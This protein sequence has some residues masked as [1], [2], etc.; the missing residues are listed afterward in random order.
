MKKRNLILAFLTL[1]LTFNVLSK[2]MDSKKIN[3]VTS[4]KYLKDLIRNVTCGDESLKIDVLIP[5]G[6]NP[7]TFH[8]D[9]KNKLRILNAKLLLLI[10][11]DLEGWSLKLNKTSKFYL[12]KHLPLTEMS[13]PH[14]CS[15]SHNDEP[16]DT[17]DTGKASK[18]HSHDHHHNDEPHDKHDTGKASKSHSHDHHHSYDIPYMALNRLNAKIP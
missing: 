12:G 8:L 7:H 2:T 13:H 16:H 11:P 10:H 9:A 4:L 1:L 17:H 3:I 14:S 6:A 18:S 15:H 5:D